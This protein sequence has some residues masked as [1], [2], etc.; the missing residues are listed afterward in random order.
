ML[1]TTFVEPSA[2]EAD[3]DVDGDDDDDDLD[4]DPDWVSG[5]TPGGPQRTS[6]IHAKVDDCHY[7]CD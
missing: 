6:T 3:E 2:A 1:D 5:M 4:K 7:E